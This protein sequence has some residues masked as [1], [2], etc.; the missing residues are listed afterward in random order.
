MSIMST[1]LALLG[2]CS[3]WWSIQSWPQYTEDC[4]CGVSADKQPRARIVGGEDATPG[5][6]PWAAALEYLEST[7]CGAAIVSDRIVLTAAHCLKKRVPIQ[8]RVGGHNT[9]KLEGT[10]LIPARAIAH[11]D[12]G[13]RSKNLG[14]DIAALRLNK[15]IKFEQFEG[16]VAPACLPEPG[17]VIDHLTVVAAGWGLTEEG[18]GEEKKS[19]VLQKVQLEVIPNVK[20]FK[21]TG[22]RVIENYMDETMLCAWGEDRDAC[23]GDSGGPLAF[24]D[25]DTQRWTL[26]GIISFG[27]GC[28]RRDYPGIYSRVA[29]HLDWVRSH[30]ISSRSKLCKN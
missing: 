7:Y 22:Y 3:M 26:V 19:K 21:E 14:S 23:G 17:H 18:G 9:S 27:V 30:L 5:E 24:W 11:P 29:F 15:R 1:W 10:M 2:M 4:K 28:G 13:R 20:C 6:F 8:V 25:D 16:R 12:Y